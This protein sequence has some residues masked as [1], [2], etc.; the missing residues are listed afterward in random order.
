MKTSSVEM[1]PRDLIEPAA[2]AER[3]PGRFLSRP[4][5]WVG[6]GAVVLVTAVVLRFWTRS[7]LWLD[8][9]NARAF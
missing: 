7:D 9:A 6:L 8:E 5:T 1:L 3:A 2:P 4:S